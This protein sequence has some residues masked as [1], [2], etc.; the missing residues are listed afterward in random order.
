MRTQKAKRF[1]SKKS[2]QDQTSGV[3]LSNATSPRRE[4]VEPSIVIDAVEARNIQFIRRDVVWAAV[5]L[6]LLL[7][8]FVVLNM[9]IAHTTQW[10]DLAQRV[11]RAGGL[12]K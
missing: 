2:Q 3:D 4:S 7:G 1:K 11:A 5:I 8:G 9:T 10:T 12:I 6:G